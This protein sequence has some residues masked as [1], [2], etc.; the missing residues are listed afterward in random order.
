MWGAPT[1]NQTLALGLSDS[2]ISTIYYSWSTTMHTLATGDNHLI[3]N[4]WSNPKNFHTLAFQHSKG[5]N[6]E[7]DSLEVPASAIATTTACGDYY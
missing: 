4:K 7:P 5:R 3:L 1:E 2:E 6:S